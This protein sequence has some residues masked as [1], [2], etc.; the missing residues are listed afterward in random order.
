M[1]NLLVSGDPSAW[2][3]DIYVMDKSRFLEFTNSNIADAFQF[4]TTEAI[5]KLKIYP[6]VFAI[7]GKVFPIRIGKITDVIPDKRKLKITFEF[8]SNLPEIEFERIGPLAKN[9]DI[10]GWEMN[11]THWAVKD[12]D[13]FEVLQA[14]QVIQIETEVQPISK[15]LPEL[16][17]PDESV[18]SLSDFIKAVLSSTN[19][20]G[21]EIF[22]RGHSDRKKYKLE[23][24]LFRK[25][26]GGNYLYLRE[27]HILYRELLVSN[28]ADFTGDVY[29]LDRLVRAQH[30]S[31]PTRLL[32]ITTNP[33][34]ALYFA[35]I[36]NDDVEGEVIL[37][38]V[39]REK[40]KYFDSDTASCIANLARLPQTEKDQINFD[41]KPDESILDAGLKAKKLLQEFNSQLPV[42]RLIHHIREE[43]SFFIAEINPS[44]LQSV[45]C[46]KGKRTNDR[47]SSQAGAFLLFGHDA[48]L[49][50]SGDDNLFIK[51]IGI[52]NKEVILKQ[53]DQ[54]DINDSTVFPYIE[55]SAL[56]LAKKYKNASSTS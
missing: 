22:Y 27:E 34:I 50:E 14:H 47:I 21:D 35:C 8:D 23:P 40:V 49:E 10:R 11:R 32:D 28:S 41:L 37:F 19:K 44:D 52:S 7:E 20:N 9:L 39:E 43:K 5:D 51:R 53:L 45:L 6:C 42:K 55:N 54:L 36:D 29:T 46:V 16:P 56:Y 25:D 24:S 48:K 17:P 13:L 31:L 2:D 38:F 12:I 18:D 3:A 30:H 33:L 1:Y 4:L 15:D 26:A